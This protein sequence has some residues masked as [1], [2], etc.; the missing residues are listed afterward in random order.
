MRPTRNHRFRTH[1]AGA[2]V[3]LAA[4]FTAAADQ[5]PEPSQG[6][7]AFTDVIDVEI[8]NVEAWVTDRKGRSVTGL[9]AVDFEVFEDGVPVE[10]SHFAEVTDAPQAAEEVATAPRPAATA[11]APR[12]PTAEEEI[13]D[14]AY[15]VIFFDES[16]LAVGSRKRVVEAVREFLDAQR[17]AAERILIVRHLGGVSAEVRFGSSAEEVRAAVDRLAAPSA[18]ATRR[19]NEKQLLM[20]LLK[21]D[22]QTARQGVGDPCT[23]FAR[24]AASRIR[25]FTEESRVQISS[26][27]RSLGQVVTFLAG[28]P[29]V[30]TLVYVSDGLELRPGADL[31]AFVDTNCPPAAYHQPTYVLPVELGRD[32]TRLAHPSGETSYVKTSVA[33]GVDDADGDGGG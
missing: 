2:A 13:E 10:I 9:E 18:A 24:S 12:T 16:Q 6:S 15:L 4:A 23:R 7:S 17:V 32:A 1:L 20:S 27:M 30:K 31:R 26:T 29:G 25:S 14:P 8:V 33:I 21:I 3:V 22:W 11:P 19:S 28:T 5:G